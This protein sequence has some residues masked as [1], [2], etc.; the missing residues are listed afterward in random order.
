MKRGN[1]AHRTSSILVYVQTI[2]TGWVHPP[3][4]DKSHDGLSL[5][6]A[7]EVVKAEPWHRGGNQVR[8]FLLLPLWRR[9][10]VLKPAFPG[11]A[12]PNLRPDCVESAAGFEL[13]RLPTQLRWAIR[14]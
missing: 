5:G 11:R 14:I 7:A 4:G 1:P 10:Q 2:P 3:C 6:T 8:R 12:S 13:A 9:A